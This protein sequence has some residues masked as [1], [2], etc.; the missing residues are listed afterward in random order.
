MVY[1]MFTAPFLDDTILSEKVGNKTDSIRWRQKSSG[2]TSMLPELVACHWRAEC[3]RQKWG[4]PSDHLPAGRDGSSASPIQT[5]LG[6]LPPAVLPIRH[7]DGHGP[8]KGWGVVRVEEVAQLVE[9]YII[10]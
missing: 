8:V 1:S 5:V 6:E 10:L 4:G 9:G 7:T 3:A 2:R